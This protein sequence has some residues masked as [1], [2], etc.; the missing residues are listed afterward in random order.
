MTLVTMTQ[1]GNKDNDLGRFGKII[2]EVED[3][4][5]VCP[6]CGLP[7]ELKRPTDNDGWQYSTNLPFRYCEICDTFRLFMDEDPRIK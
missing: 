4:C 5:H 3:L 1:T 2:S 7:M 6:T